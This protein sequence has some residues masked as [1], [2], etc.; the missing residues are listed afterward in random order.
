MRMAR[1]WFVPVMVVAVSAATAPAGRAQQPVRPLEISISAHG[2]GAI[3]TEFLEQRVQGDE[4][5]GERELVAKSSPLIGGSV[6]FSRWEMSEVRL[7][8]DWTGTEIEYR[9]DSAIESDELDQEGL[10]D[11]HLVVAQLAVIRHLMPR[12]AR[13]SPYL[14]LGVNVAV[15]ALDEEPG[16]AVGATEETQVRFGATTGIGARFAASP[17]MAL[18]IEIDRA[19]VGNPFDGDSAYRVAGDTFDE[20]STVGILRLMGGLSYTL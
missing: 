13:V 20:P 16:G 11:L 4:G 1:S 3:F 19:T 18:R 9:D 2:G 6:S 5:A 15:W 10:A 7:G 14:S 8:V 17:R 12:D